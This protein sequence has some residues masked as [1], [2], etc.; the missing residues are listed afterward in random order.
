MAGI[1]HLTEALIRFRDERNWKQFH[2]LKNL[3]VSL[4]LEASELLEL[5]QWKTD[6]ALESSLESDEA[7]RDNLKD[8]CADV[9]LYLLQIA[10]HAGI[11]LLKA[12]EEKMRKNA[13]RYPAAASYG[14]A[15]KYSELDAADSPGASENSNKSGSSHF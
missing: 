14:S 8:E 3:I 4:N 5:A 1:E 9:F 2:T 10:D 7:F 15:R 12:A 11:D 13:V 6:E